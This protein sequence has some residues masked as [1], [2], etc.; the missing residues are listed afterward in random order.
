MVEGYLVGLHVLVVGSSGCGDGGGGYGDEVVVLGNV[1]LATS[2]AGWWR[3]EEGGLAFRPTI[4][5]LPSAA[6]AIVKPSPPSA[7]VA[8]HFF[9][10]TSQNLQVPSLE[11]EASSASFVGFHATLSIGPVCPLSSVLFFT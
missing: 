4:R 10:F 8:V 6:H 9:V 1:S 7:T 2:L 3:W 5:T 11:T